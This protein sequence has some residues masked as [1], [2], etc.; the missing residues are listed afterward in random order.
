[1]RIE[2]EMFRA[3]TDTREHPVRISRGNF[4]RILTTTTLSQPGVA[5]KDVS[6][7]CLDTRMG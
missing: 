7:G 3:V 1:M 6:E 4:S 5:L 2:R